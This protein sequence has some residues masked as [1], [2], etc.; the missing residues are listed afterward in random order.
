MRFGVKMLG[1]RSKVG[2][3]L[4]RMGLANRLSVEPHNLWSQLNVLEGCH[5]NMELV[6]EKGHKRP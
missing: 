1:V 5:V 3:K 4:A 6:L 2:F